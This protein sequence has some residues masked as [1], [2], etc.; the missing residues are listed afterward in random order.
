MLS[1]VRGRSKSVGR[2]R[3][4]GDRPSVDFDRPAEKTT[5]NDRKSTFFRNFYK[6]SEFFREIESISRK[7][8]SNFGRIF[9]RKVDRGRVDLKRPR[10]RSVRSI[11]GDRPRTLFQILITT[12]KMIHR[13]IQDIAWKYS[14][15]DRIRFQILWWWVQELTPCL[16]RKSLDLPRPGGHAWSTIVRK[17]WSGGPPWWGLLTPP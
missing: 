6:I 12:Y 3:F 2:G 4:F 8:W 7:I 16:T 5:E 14:G 9:D 1:S 10:S 17:W 15:F 11:F 13:Q